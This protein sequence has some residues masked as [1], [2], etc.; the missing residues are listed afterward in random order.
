MTTLLMCWRCKGTGRESRFTCV[1]C[2]GSGRRVCSGGD[3]VVQDERGMH[4]LVTWHQGTDEETRR[5][6]LC[7]EPWPCGAVVRAKQVE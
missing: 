7:G 4:T 2:G 3:S 5:C 6:Y 1:T